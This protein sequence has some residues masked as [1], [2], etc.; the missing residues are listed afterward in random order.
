MKID[1]LLSIIVFLMNRELVSARVLAERFGVTIRTIQRDMETIELAGIPIMAIQGPNGGYGIMENYKM[2]SQLVS[3]EDLYY[4]ITSLK[5]VADTLTDDHM[6]STLEKMK[7][8]LP[9]RESGLFTEK[10]EKLS[11]D[12]SM[13]GGD[14]RHQAAFRT[15]REAVETERLLRFEYTNNRLESV[16]RTVEPMTIAFKWRAWYLFAWC[17]LK[18]DYRTFR[19]S[20][21]RQPEILAARFK[22]RDESFDD[23]VSRPPM[24]GNTPMTTVKLRFHPSMRKLVEEFHADEN[25]TVEP[26]GSLIVDTTLPNDGW[27]YGFILSYGEFVEVLEPESFRSNMKTI[28]AKINE[29][30]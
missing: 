24:T 1:R 16:V 20:R 14:P 19:I 3:I 27:V 17:R 5:S 9:S 25:C 7:T 23:F 15:V 30:Y 12:F 8:L 4:I 6:D 18:E 21:I 11:I 13:L 26:D 29:K 10:N 28:T 22:R 2:D